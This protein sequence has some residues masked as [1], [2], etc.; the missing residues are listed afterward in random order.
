[1]RVSLIGCGLSD[2]VIDTNY[3]ECSTGCP[4]STIFNRTINNNQV[5]GALFFDLSM[6]YRLSEIFN[7][8]AATE[9]F[10]VV[11]NLMDKDPEIF[12][13]Y[14]ANPVD[15]ASNPTYYDILG[16]ELRFGVRAQF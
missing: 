10:L 3:V 15:P 6:S 12:P 11:Q 4:A 7:F 1:M 9:M 5:D 8:Q 2:G 14:G 16:R 13:R